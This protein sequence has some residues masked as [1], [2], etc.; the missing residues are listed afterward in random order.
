MADTIYPGD[1]EYYKTLNAPDS[2]NK[3]FKKIIEY[4][5]EVEEMSSIKSYD[6]L[7]RSCRAVESINRDQQTKLWEWKN[8]AYSEK[9]VAE[10]QARIDR[11][12]GF[13]IGQLVKFSPKALHH[14]ADENYMWGITHV[15]GRVT[16]RNKNTV[17]VIEVSRRRST[18]ESEDTRSFGCRWRMAPDKDIIIDE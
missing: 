15:I 5:A 8:Q 12:K 17:S 7:T 2:V 3:A 18:A 13:K 4:L 11:I 6:F 9:K 16:R 1:P 14:A 10:K